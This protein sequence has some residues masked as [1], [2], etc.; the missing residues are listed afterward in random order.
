MDRKNVIRKLNDIQE[1][2]LRIG[3]NGILEKYHPDMNLDN[4]EA[5]NVFRLYKHVYEN[6]KKRVLITLGI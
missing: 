5:E 2:I 6:M 3:W 1:E 4:A